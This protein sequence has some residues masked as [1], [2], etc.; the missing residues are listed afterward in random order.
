[1]GSSEPQESGTN[2]A[3]GTTDHPLQGPEGAQPSIVKER[4]KQR[5]WFHDREREKRHWQKMR[6]AQAT[7]A[8]PASDSR[9][10]KPG[11]VKGNS[12]LSSGLPKPHLAPL[13]NC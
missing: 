11:Q 3:Q 13:R 1:M 5:R 10:Q 12:D 2:H 7:R 6:R 4:T 8:Q 9:V